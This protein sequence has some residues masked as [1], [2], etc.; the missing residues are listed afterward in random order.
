MLRLW[1]LPRHWLDRIF[2]QHRPLAGIFELFFLDD[3]R[4]GILVTP[5][6]LKFG[7]EYKDDCKFFLSCVLYF[8]LRVIDKVW[9]R[10]NGSERLKLNWFPF[11]LKIISCDLRGTLVGLVA[12]V[13]DR[14][15]F[16]HFFCL[17]T[18]LGVKEP[19]NYIDMDIFHFLFYWL[20]DYLFCLLI[21]RQNRQGLL[22]FLL[23]FAL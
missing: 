14:L 16:R 4:K 2:Q 18:L 23:N 6:M 3:I 22:D 1:A 7:F 8:K 5:S 17:T 9:V 12:Q 19:K 10:L 21:S 11:W 13:G 15:N 20:S